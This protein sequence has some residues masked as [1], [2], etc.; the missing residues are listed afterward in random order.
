M[1]MVDLVLWQIRARAR[2]GGTPEVCCLGLENSREMKEKSHRAT[3]R[4]YRSGVDALRGPYERRLD[5]YRLYNPSDLPGRRVCE[6]VC[7]SETSSAKR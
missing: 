4:C 3:R 5:G 2:P 1:K 7:R 6:A